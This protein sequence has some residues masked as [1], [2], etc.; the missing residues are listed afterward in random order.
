[1]YKLNRETACRIVVTS[2][3]IVKYKKD[4]PLPASIYFL[5]LFY[6]IISVFVMSTL[7]FLFIY[8]IICV[9]V[10]DTLENILLLKLHNNWIILG[11]FCYSPQI[12][13][14]M[15][16]QKLSFNMFNG[17]SSVRCIQKSRCSKIYLFEYNNEWIA[18]FMKNFLRSLC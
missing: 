13:I 16:L 1:M 4:I 10:C 2:Y 3:R 5:I 15:L 6:I 14:I 7:A 11:V 8:Y 17:V 18:K 9:F 12:F